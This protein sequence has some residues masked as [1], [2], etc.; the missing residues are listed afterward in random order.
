MTGFGSFIKRRL[1]EQGVREAGQDLGEAVQGC[2]LGSS[3]AVA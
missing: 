1:E 2:A 3:L